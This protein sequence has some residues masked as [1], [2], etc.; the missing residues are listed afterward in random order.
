MNDQQFLL[1]K[2]LLNAAEACDL[3]QVEQLL[4]QGADPLGSTDKN[5]L[6]EDILGEL[7]CYST[8][9]EKLA[10]AMPEM[11]EL[12]FSYGMKIAASNDPA[13]DGNK[14]NPLWSLAFVSN[15]SGMA[16]LRVLLDHKLDCKSAEILV[17]HILGDMEICDGCYVGDRR[18]MK[19]CAYSLKM[20]MLT[21]SYPH[22]IRNSPYIAECISLAENQ[23][24]RLS[25]FS[26]WNRFTYHVD[27]STCDNIPHGLRNATL[28]IEDGDE[29]VWKMII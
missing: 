8:D 13:D 6:D 25:E 14:P 2:V 15:E 29:I 20:V 3:E 1:N 21:A 7:F 5:V 22:I 23:A 16:M 9:D 19:Q 12:F 28:H 4:K 10:K 11:L 27:L 17:G 18:W 26:D 24:E